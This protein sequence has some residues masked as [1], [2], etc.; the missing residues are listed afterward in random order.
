MDALVDGTV[1]IMMPI[2]DRPGLEPTGQKYLLSRKDRRRQSLKIKSLEQPF[3]DE[4]NYANN[5][6]LIEEDFM[7]CIRLA[8]I[9]HEATDR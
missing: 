5:D 4:R 6:C 1:A 7:Y 2:W 8:S 9:S 3:H